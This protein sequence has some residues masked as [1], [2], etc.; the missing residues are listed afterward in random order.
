MATLTAP[1]CTDEREVDPACTE[2][3]ARLLLKVPAVTE[4]WNEV[5][6]VVAREVAA[7]AVVVELSNESVTVEPTLSCE[8]S[9]RLLELTSLTEVI[10]TEEGCTLTE[11]VLAD[12]ATAT[13]KELIDDVVRGDLASYV[14]VVIAVVMLTYIIAE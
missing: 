14:F 9:K 1:D 12:R 4:F 6:A 8:A 11:E 13:L 2:A 7:A 5:E 3:V 10:T